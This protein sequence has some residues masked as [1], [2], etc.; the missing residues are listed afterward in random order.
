MAFV[1]AADPAERPTPRVLLLPVGDVE[2][3]DV[4]H[5]SGMRATGSHDVAATD[6]FVPELHTMP[7]DDL[8]GEDPPGARL[9]GEAFLR[10]PMSPVLCL[11]AAASA[12]GAA[13]AAVDLC[14]DHMSARLLP[15]TPGDRQAEQA[16]SQARLAEA[17]ATVRASR[18]VWSDAIE[19][20]SRAYEDGGS[21]ARA[22]R[23]EFR[24]AAAHAVRLARQAVEIAGV[25]MGASAYFEGSP[26]QRIERDLAVLK[27]H[28]VYDWDRVTQLAGKLELGIAPLATDM[29]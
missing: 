23:G 15:H 3:I 25:G 21:L 16:T 5:T 18:L 14:R 22:E 11:Y 10:Y 24:L 9:H 26:F 19:R 13:E 1:P 2:I 4:W 8:R 7:V 27:G 12:V 6:V 28:V 20:L 17:R 29:L